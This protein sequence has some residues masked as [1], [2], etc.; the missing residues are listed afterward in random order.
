MPRMVRPWI[1]DTRSH[2][3][4]RDASS[5]SS[6][7]SSPALSRDEARRVYDRIGAWQD[8]QAFYED[9]AIGLLLRHERVAPFG[10]PSEV[11]VARC[12]A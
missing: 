5:G 2:R 3:I 7:M 8:S 4:E 6:S 12:R 1:E 9:R 11:V 10:V